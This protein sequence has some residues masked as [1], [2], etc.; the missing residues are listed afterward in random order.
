MIEAVRAKLIEAEESGSIDQSLEDMFEDATR[1]LERNTEKIDLV[2]ISGVVWK[3]SVN[4]K[5]T[6]TLNLAPAL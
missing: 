6:A 3:M 2:C 5:P 4:T 1:G